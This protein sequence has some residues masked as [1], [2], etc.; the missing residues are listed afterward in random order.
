MKNTLL[1]LAFIM[2]FVSYQGFAGGSKEKSPTTSRI[3]VT[4]KIV[5]FMLK[6]DGSSDGLKFYLSKPFTLK[7][8]EQK[9]TA[10]VEFNK[11]MVI[12]NPAG[13]AD[14][15]RIAFTVNNE[16]RLTDIPGADKGRELH[17]LFQDRTLIFKRN[18][19]QNCYELSSVKI[20]DNRYYKTVTSN[21][22]PRLYVHGQDKRNISDEVQVLPV[23][24]AQSDNKQHRDVK[25]SAGKSPPKDAGNF[26]DSYKHTGKDNRFA[27]LSRNIMGK[28]SVTHESVIA[29]AKK[30]NPALSR[31]DTAIINEYFREADGVNID[32]AIAQ[33]LYATNFFKNQTRIQNNNY[34]GFAAE[35]PGNGIFRNMNTGVKAHIQHLKGY[36]KEVVKSGE[37]VDPRYH[38]AFERGFRGIQFED[39][40]SRWTASPVNY[41]ENIEAILVGI[42]AAGARW[43]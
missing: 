39:L 31:N 2:C 9:E 37:V 41:G 1:I 29:Y 35:R 21:E 18:V 17:V 11:G 22:P 16:G 3:P 7:I 43:H 6:N 27:A 10:E 13:P 5:E 40:Y 12:L 30:K 36:A 20:L 23:T 14:E 33:M 28:G 8:Y 24:A 25:D 38:L 34:A 4:S 15:K 26:N 32:I 19:Q 42:G